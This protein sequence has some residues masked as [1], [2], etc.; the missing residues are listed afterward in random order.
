MENRVV[1]GAVRI[2]IAIA[3]LLGGASA[4][5]SA[6]GPRRGECKYRVLG[7]EIRARLAP[8]SHRIEAVDRVTLRRTGRP[9]RAWTFTLNEG[10]EVR[11]VRDGRRDIPF[12][13]V[14]GDGDGESQGVAWE[15]EI[16]GF[17][18]RRDVTFEVRYEGTIYDSLKVPS[19]SRDVVA[20]QTTGQ[21]GEEGVYLAE[22]SAWYPHRP[23]ARGLVP[24]MLEVTLP[25]AYEVISQGRRAMDGVRDGLRTVRWESRHPS[26][27][28]YLIAGKYEVEERDVDGVKVYA[29]FFP[30]SRDLRES[31][32]SATERYLRMYSEMIGPYPYAKFAV[33]E[34]FF[35]TGYGMPS[36]TLLGSAVIRLPFIVHT[37][38]GHEV[39]HN[40]WGNSVFVEPESGNWCES[41]TTYM[42][43][44]YYKE[45]KGADAA[46]DYRM[47]INRSYSNYV[48]EN[49]DFSLAEFTSRTTP[50]TRSVGYGKGALVFH[51]IRR[52]LGDEAFHRALQ[53]FFREHR[54]DYAGWDDLK[55]AFE[56]EGRVDLDGYFD[57]WVE[58][59]GAPL[60][61]LEGA[62][63]D[64]DAVEVTIAQEG[65]GAPYRIAV[66]V[67]VEYPDGRQEHVVEL[68]EGRRTVRLPVR[69]RPVSVSVDPDHHL[70][71]R[72]DDL[73]I[74]PSLSMVLG[75]EEEMIVL[76]DR[77]AG[78]VRGAYDMLAGQINRT[79]GAR[80]VRADAIDPAGA[81]SGA[82]F[83]LGGPEENS[84]WET[85]AGGGPAGLRVTDGTVSLA[86]R[87]YPAAG[88]AFLAVGRR[89]GDPTQ[90][91]AVFFGSDAAEIREA[92]RKLVHYG[93]YGYLAFEGGR[94]VAKGSWRL[95]DSPLRVRFDAERAD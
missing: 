25:E 45:W 40:W 91:V 70:F 61:R 42:A 33:V 7:H 69:G 4:A 46:R 29:F 68:R 66:P 67:V 32:L 71:R 11:S 74:P 9:C 80:V 16:K 55:E 14:E 37:S 58:G 60:L 79:G 75:A 63:L 87:D 76:P 18:H 5:V 50:A 62:R 92:G 20:N 85:L 83:L 47:E 23:G 51:G 24:F 12:R 64:G 44:Y 19:F 81:G 31:Y 73:E 1:P 39:L 59:V 84:G 41:L 22:E 95:E 27:T 15:V 52:I 57:E 35:E 28:I 86:G 38:L 89:P 34:N 54:F 26:D 90:G 56:R 78:E 49:N 53:A 94:N 43:D 72:M 88:H 93:K 2:V 77:A 3:L 17:G 36:F 13:R 6:A 21:I 82:V 30:E 65:A 8:E 48:H 10:L